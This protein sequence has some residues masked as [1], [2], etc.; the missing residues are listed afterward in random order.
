MDVKH[1]LAIMEIANEPKSYAD[2]LILVHTDT[3]TVFGPYFGETA[4]CAAYD[5]AIKTGRPFIFQIWA[6]KG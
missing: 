6:H 3:H 1:F 4:Q 5:K 2:S